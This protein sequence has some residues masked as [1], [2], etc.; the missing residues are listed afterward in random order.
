MMYNTTINTACSLFTQACVNCFLFHLYNYLDS[1]LPCKELA[2][3][4]R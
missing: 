2:W 4:Y 3:D 1:R